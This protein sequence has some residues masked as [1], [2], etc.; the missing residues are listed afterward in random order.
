MMTI[1]YTLEL[2]ETKERLDA[3]WNFMSPWA[4]KTFYEI[5]ERARR[6]LNRPT[7]GQ[8]TLILKLLVEA[9]AKANGGTAEK[10]KID[11]TRVIKMFDIAAKHKK[12]PKVYF[13]AGDA[14][15]AV[16]PAK[17]TSA[18]HGSLYVKAGSLYLGKI[19]REGEF[20]PSRDARNLPVAEALTK[21]AADPAAAAAAFARE[22]KRCCF[23]SLRLEH[24][25]SVKVGYGP[26]CADNHGLPWGR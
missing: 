15:F 2:G 11:L 14:E 7:E 17:A 20:S 21:F 4:Q 18:N 8:R 9:E 16:T 23:C 22:T 10:T 3:A 26:D 6:Y 1:G 25:A 12:S 13:L 19:S 24:P 5:Q